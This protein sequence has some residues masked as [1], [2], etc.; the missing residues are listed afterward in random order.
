MKRSAASATGVS[1][2]TGTG[3]VEGVVVTLPVPP[4]GDNPLISGVVV[5]GVVNF[6]PG[7]GTTQLT[8]R[9]RR[10]TTIAGAL[11]GVAQVHALAAGVP[12]GV[13]FSA[14]DTAPVAGGSYC[15]TVQQT[16]GPATAAGSAGVAVVTATAS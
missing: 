4:L 16:A 3:L 15:V 12:G 9:V 2:G 5:D 1:V 13:P 6:T 7:V 8:I 11:V 14:F 10:G